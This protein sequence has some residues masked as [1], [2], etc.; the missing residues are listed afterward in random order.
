MLSVIKDIT[1]YEG[2]ENKGRKH[3][4]NKKVFEND[5][6]S[7]YLVIRFTFLNILPGLGLHIPGRCGVAGAG[8]C[9]A[10]DPNVAEVP[11]ENR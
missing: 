8:M 11:G 6:L 10:G 1:Y 5:F 9:L 7:L 2:K 3:Y 4:R